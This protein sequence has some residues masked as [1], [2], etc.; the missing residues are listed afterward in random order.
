M[1]EATRIKPGDTVVLKVT[2]VASWPDS[3]RITVE[4][5]GQR[6]TLREDHPA[7]VGIEPCG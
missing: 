2:V 3:R 4:V 7:V 5:N 1:P 6:I